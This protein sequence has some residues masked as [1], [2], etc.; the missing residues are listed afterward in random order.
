MGEEERSSRMGTS[1]LSSNLKSSLGSESVPAGSNRDSSNETTS[2]AQTH[3]KQHMDDFF[4]YCDDFLY[5]EVFSELITPLGITFCM[6]GMFTEHSN[7]QIINTSF[8]KCYS[9]VLI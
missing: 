1:E 6:S 7:N 3:S 4:S 8:Y 5:V 9:F 2:T